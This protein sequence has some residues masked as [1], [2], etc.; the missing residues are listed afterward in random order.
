MKVIEIVSAHL[1][2][3]SFDGLVQADAECGCKLGDLAPCG[4]CGDD[5][6]PAY[7][8]ASNDAPGEWAMYRTK[9]AAQASRAAS[10]AA[11]QTTELGTQC[12]EG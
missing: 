11:E 9:E 3:H 5:C 4:C 1:L 7:L 10:G 2:A 6:E 8:G 12:R